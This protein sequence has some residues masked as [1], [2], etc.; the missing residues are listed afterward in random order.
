MN[1][2]DKLIKI[3]MTKKPSESLNVLKHSNRMEEIIPELSRS[4]MMSQNRHHDATVWEHTL[5]V[6]DMVPAILELRMAALLHDIGKTETKSVDENNEVHFYRHENIGA[7]MSEIIL[8]RLAFPNDFIETVRVL[9]KNHMRLKAFGNEGKTTKKAL[10]RLQL[11]LGD[12]LENLLI[13][14]HAD[15]LSHA[16]DSMMPEQIPNIRT[17]LEMLY[18]KKSDEA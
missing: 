8:K 17:K 4:Y 3:L 6:V 5:R 2:R 1:K 7:N 15:N 12:N 10:R 11:D 16:L 14:C 13:L 9:V 18:K